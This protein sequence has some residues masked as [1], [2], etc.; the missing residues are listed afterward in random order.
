MNEMNFFDRIKLV[1]VAR[2]FMALYQYQEVKI[3][4]IEGIFL[5]NKGAKFPLIRISNKQF[6]NIQEFNEDL[7]VM[8]RM[9]GEY[10]K[11][12]QIDNPKCLAIYFGGEVET[13][14]DNIYSVVLSD[15]TE[16]ANNEIMKN[17]FPA[18]IDN[19]DLSSFDNLISNVQNQVN[20]NMLNNQS[21]DTIK[22]KKVI[23]LNAKMDAIK[24]LKFTFYFPIIFLIINIYA[25]FTFTHMTTFQYDLSFYAPFV[26]EF[27]QYY[28]M[29]TS[30][31]LNSS[32]IFIFI[33]AY[34]YFKY[35]GF[36]ELR[37]GTA[38]TIVVFLIG[39]VF[40]YASMFFV[41]NGSILS[42]SAPLLAILCGAYIGTI[43]TPS[44]RP[45]LKANIM[46][47]LFL[48]IMT[49]AFI[50]IESGDFIPSIFAFL[51]SI[52]AVY[53]VGI[54]KSKVKLNYLGYLAVVLL[55]IGVS[56]F[57]PNQTL[58]QSF[59]FEQN[60]IDYVAYNNKKQAKVYTEKLDK[61]YQDIGA[62]T[63][64]D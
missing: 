39:L 56:S 32:I 11:I 21:N 5:Q 42:G 10:S 24:K 22:Q 1:E 53:V 28:R 15:N 16:L 26:L 30:V 62:I 4:N 13:Q 18:F 43:L 40:L 25:I 31:F 29:F 3:Q 2:R 52:A 8:R 14:V 33:V 38:K 6:N 57:I 51:G 60:Y 48:L 7:E 12:S 19:F 27:N 61:Y 36:I 37:L 35:G 50:F 54:K 47:S 46:R 41:A 63:Y 45:A 23:N 64:D 34:F 20:P 58:K 59:S 55:I 49:G 44:E 17:D 9:L